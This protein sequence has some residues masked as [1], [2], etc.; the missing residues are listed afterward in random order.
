VTVPTGTGPEVV[1]VGEAMALFLAVPGVPLAQAT[2]ASID[3]AGAESNVAVALARLGHRTALW[4]RVGTDA[5]GNAVLR[6]LRGEGVDVG[7]VVRDADGPTGVLVRDCHADRPVQVAYY[8]AGSAGSRLQPVDLDVS[9]LIEGTVLHVTGITAMLSDSAHAA[10][11]SAL[12]QAR[13]RGATVSF[14]PNIRTTLAPLTVW[15]DRVAPL[16]T[17][18]D[19]L[20]ISAEE[21]VALEI[22]EQR[23]LDA[24]VGCVVTRA[25]SAGAAAHT[26]EGVLRCPAHPVTPVDP[27]GA[28]DAFTAGFLS[29]WLRR[30]ALQDCLQ[31]AAVVAALCVAAPGDLTGLPDAATRDAVRAAPTD[32]ATLR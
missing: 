23:L 9:A 26:A 13:S 32:H 29:G 17:A 28:G 12:E 18:A 20:F 11:V 1:C 31:E 22:T 2:T 19:L 3:V 4:G 15:R 25:G 7:A 24:G 6:R 5:L 16:L 30:R 8:R 27:V 10:A 14:D 21:L